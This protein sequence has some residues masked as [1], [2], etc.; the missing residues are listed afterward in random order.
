MEDVKD[1]H[2]VVGVSDDVVLVSVVVSPAKASDFQ[3]LS[4]LQ[5]G[6]GH[7]AQNEKWYDMPVRRSDGEQLE[8]EWD[9]VAEKVN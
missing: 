7:Q 3:K 6:E 9:E 5:Q 1:E 8:S 2:D 4:E